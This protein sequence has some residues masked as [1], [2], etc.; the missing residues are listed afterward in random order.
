MSLIL[1]AWPEDSLS[2]NSDCL[3]FSVSVWSLTMR[4][5]FPGAPLGRRAQVSQVTVVSAP[6]MLLSCPIKASEMGTSRAMPTVRNLDSLVVIQPGHTIDVESRVRSTS[7]YW[8]SA[9][10]SRFGSFR[11]PTT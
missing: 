3:K 4:T 1:S 5:A 10:F 9:L 8:L 11:S 2:S 7:A 6:T